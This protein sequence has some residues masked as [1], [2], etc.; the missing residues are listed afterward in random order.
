[1][2][3]IT[4]DELERQMMRGDQALTPFALVNAEGTVYHAFWHDLGLGAFIV[5][6]I[7]EAQVFHVSSLD[8][9]GIRARLMDEGE[10]VDER[11]IRLLK[12]RGKA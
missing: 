10:P 8:G 3:L 9:T 11:V 4:I 1:M 5:P 2:K 6:E 12:E 7:T